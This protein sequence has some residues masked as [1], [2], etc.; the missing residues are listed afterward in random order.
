[1]KKLIINSRHGLHCLRLPFSQLHEYTTLHSTTS[2]LLISHPSFQSSPIE[3]SVV[4][5]RAGYTPDDYPTSTQWDL[6]L[7]IEKSKAIKCPSVGLQLAGS[8]KVQQVSAQAEVLA[9]FLNI[10]I[11][12][13]TLEPAPKVILTKE[14]ERKIRE[15]FVGLYPMDDTEAG[16]AAEKLVRADS[17]GFVLKPQ[18]EGG[19]NN[20][21]RDDIIPFLDVLAA[22]DT[23]REQAEGKEG[24]VKGKEGYILMDLIESPKGANQIMVK[25]GRGVGDTVE[26]VS[27]LGI[28]GIILFKKSKN[29]AEILLNE[30]VGHLLRT[31]GSNDDEGGVQVG[32]SVIDSMCLI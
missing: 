30:T 19:G 26:V 17:S 10:G 25:S 31:K 21:Y 4:Y 20:I 3:I 16:S 15:S 1:M 24:L 11:T 6:R 9:Q 29:G 14:D 28:Y 7:L 8:K 23:K 27:E 22:G 2:T 5:F 18:R 32:F 13:S 12:Q